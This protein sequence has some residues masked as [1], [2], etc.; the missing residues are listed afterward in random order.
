MENNMGENV[1][2][3]DTKRD[4]VE[5]QRSD[6]TLDT[7]VTDGEAAVATQREYG[8]IGR[9]VYLGIFLGLVVARIIVGVAMAS[10]GGGPRYGQIDDAS[11]IVFLIFAVL[12]TIP[13]YF[14]IK[15]IG[16]HP[17]L[18]LLGLIP[19][20]ALVVSIPCLLCPRGYADTKKLD[21]IA[22]VIVFIIL[23]LLA[24]GIVAAIIAA[25]GS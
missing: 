3:N 10:S 5:D 6:S 24:V 11:V 17:L 16:W 21:V 9:L 23:G 8:G 4:A 7:P 20:V 12:I 22:K 13:M 15:N 2:H 25:L 14:R 18:C 1:E 19:I